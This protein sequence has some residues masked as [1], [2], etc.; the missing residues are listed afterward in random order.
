MQFAR[1]AADCG[2]VGADSAS[3]H[4][5]VGTTGTYTS[6]TNS[7]RLKLKKFAM[8]PISWRH[9]AATTV[10]TA[11]IACSDISDLIFLMEIYISSCLCPA[12]CQLLQT[13]PAGILDGRVSIAPHDDGGLKNQRRRC[14]NLLRLWRIE[15]HHSYRDGCKNHHQQADEEIKAATSLMCVNR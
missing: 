4:H 5:H 8:V 12:H 7:G 15:E 2:I 10:V 3:N 14:C 1:G 11:N 13:Q 6:V 9:G